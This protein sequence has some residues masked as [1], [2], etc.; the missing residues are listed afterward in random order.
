VAE[1]KVQ[2]EKTID[3]VLI[4]HGSNGAGCASQL[5]SGSSLGD[6]ISPVTQ[7]NPT[8]VFPRAT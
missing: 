7:V 3:L 2:P 6:A 5:T 8:K 1:A 4:E